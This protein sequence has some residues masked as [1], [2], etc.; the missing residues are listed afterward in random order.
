MFEALLR[1]QSRN[2][3]SAVLFFT[4]RS[5]LFTPFVPINKNVFSTFASKETIK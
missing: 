1:L 3:A 2:G 5:S 4:L